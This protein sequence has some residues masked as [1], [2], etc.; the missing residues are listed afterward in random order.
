MSSPPFP[1][2]QSP[3][4]VPAM[5]TPTLASSALPSFTVICSTTI[6]APPLQVLSTVVDTNTWP[7]WNA[8]CKSATVTHTPPAETVTLNAPELQALVGKAGHLYTGVTA[9]FSAYMTPD[10]TSPSKSPE[11]VTL[12]E[13]FEREGRTGYRVAWRFGG[14]PHM[15][16]HAERVQEF[17]EVDGADG[18]VATAYYSYE[19]FGGLLV[20]VMRWMKA[21]E[22]F[23]GFSRWMGGLKGLYD[24]GSK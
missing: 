10:A 24:G 15:L 21:G 12:L 19:T 17:V 20:P 16:L 8:F 2:D 18:G 4:M 13:R 9:V 6:A 7:S 1:M 3:K 5:P 14:M 11:E 23:D 22:L